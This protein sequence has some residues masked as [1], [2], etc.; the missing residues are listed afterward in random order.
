MDF[1]ITCS[2]LALILSE[3]NINS[4]TTLTCL[5]ATNTNIFLLLLNV[6]AEIFFVLNVDQSSTS[7]YVLAVTINE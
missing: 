7:Q 3:L 6:T 2:L 5:V 1:D 4:L